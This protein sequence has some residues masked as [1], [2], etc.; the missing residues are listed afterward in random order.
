MQQKRVGCEQQG[1]QDKD[2]KQKKRTQVDLGG[3][4]AVAVDTSPFAFVHSVGI[5]HVRETQS[6][7]LIQT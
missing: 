1:L 4:S 5:A 3:A 6:I 7:N 2:G